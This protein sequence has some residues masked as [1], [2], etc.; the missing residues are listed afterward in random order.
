MQYRHDMNTFKDLLKNPAISQMPR[1]KNFFQARKK[2]ERRLSVF[3]GH[4]FQNSTKWTI[5]QTRK[6]SYK[7]ARW[8][9]YTV[10]RI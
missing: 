6:L 1:T 9:T 3:V 10:G 4:E 5:G 7:T 8:S 2:L